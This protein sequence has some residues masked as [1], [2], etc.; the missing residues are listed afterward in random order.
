MLETSDKKASLIKGILGK[1]KR[2]NSDYKASYLP[3]VT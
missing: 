3:D 2:K 1:F